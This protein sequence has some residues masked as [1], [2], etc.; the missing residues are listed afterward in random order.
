MIAAFAASQGILL[1][2]SQ[3]KQRDNDMLGGHIDATH[4]T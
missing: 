1:E 4:L 2:I 3:E